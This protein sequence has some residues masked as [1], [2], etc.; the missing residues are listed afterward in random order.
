MLN[1]H[2]MNILRPLI[3][4][5]AQI[6][7]LPIHK[8]K[9]ELWRDHNELRSARPMVLIDQV[10]WNE[11]A[12]DG[13]LTPQ[14]EDPYWRGVETELLRKIYGW[15]HMPVDMVFNPYISL[16]K[17]LHNSGW[18]IDI[19][20]DVISQSSDAEVSSH[21]YHNVLEDE[22]DIEKIRM[23][24]YTLDEEKMR[25]IAQEADLLCEGIIPYKM[26]GE[27]LH[28]GIWDKIG[29]WMGVQNC[30]F[31]LID[32]PEFLHAIMEKLT[33]GLLHEI[34]SL[35]KIKAYDVT[36]NIT[37][38][39][40]TFLD[41][42]PS[43]DCDLNYGTTQQ[44]WA[45]GL[46]QLF[47]ATS[48]EVTAEFEVPYMNRVFPHF[49]AIYYGCC[50][51]LDDRMDV[52]ATL[53]NVRKIS[54]SPWSDREHFAQVMPDWCIMSAKPNPALLAASSFDEEAVRKDLRA[55]IDAAC[56]NNRNLELLQK[57]ISTVRCEPERLWRWAEIAM[58]EVQR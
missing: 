27:I 36:G 44:G 50:E 53:K 3:Q 52:I 39:S 22:E 40:H 13:K 54:C 16:P 14:C 2:D 24:E 33:Q 10:C 46:A 15:N 57:D 43:K 9:R 1:Q 41:N 35:N 56:R 42:L 19:E 6:A 34:E 29:Q 37:H 7:D 8:T 5:Y 21:D 55:T 18:G 48:P 20:E 28:L 23:P 58:E 32:R 11:M 49:G 25:L 4:E 51:R 26:Q 31:E 45:F 30:Y 17:P 47:T 38:C 12:V